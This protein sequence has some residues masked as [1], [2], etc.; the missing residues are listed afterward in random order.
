MTNARKEAHE[1]T[2]NQQIL[3]ERPESVYLSLG[4]NLGDREANLREAIKRITALGLEITNASSIYETEPVGYKDQPWFLNQAIEV[5]VAPGLPLHDV[6]EVAAGLE[7]SW[8]KEPGI[9]SY[10]W[11]CR[12]LREML[13]IEG[14]MGRDRTIPGGPR[15]IDIDILIYGEMAGCFAETLGDPDV[16]GIAR[17]GAPFLTL[18]HPRMHERRF[19][20]QPLCEIAPEIV[21]PVLGKTC[22]EMLAS[23]DDASTV[24]VHDKS[25]GL[26]SS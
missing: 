24:S 6:A 4:S 19:V 11:I 20:I 7:A 13:A 18:P 12:L 3:A 25:A 22:R 16:P 14:A 10:F 9:T 5:R 1:S 8:D 23:L 15:T 17:A 2:S 26:I 21:H